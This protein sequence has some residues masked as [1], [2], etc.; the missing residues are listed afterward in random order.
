M[1]T[2]H[3]AIRSDCLGEQHQAGEEISKG[4]EE[5]SNKT[6]DLHKITALPS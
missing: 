1:T 3:V 4:V 2:K 6:H 5:I